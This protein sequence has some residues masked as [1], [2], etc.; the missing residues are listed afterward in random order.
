[1]LTVNNQSV[2]SGTPSADKNLVA[3]CFFSLVQTECGLATLH[4]LGPHY[5]G[6]LVSKWLR[7][8]AGIGVRNEQHSQYNKI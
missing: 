7:V 4:L 6:H 2:L 5:T 3:A 1:V 8:E